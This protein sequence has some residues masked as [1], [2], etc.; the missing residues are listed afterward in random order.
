MA[1][2]N[3]LTGDFMQS[4]NSEQKVDSVD[5]TKYMCSYYIV[6]HNVLTLDIIMSLLQPDACWLA[7]FRNVLALA[8]LNIA[9]IQIT[10]L[11]SNELS[12]C[13]NMGLLIRNVRAPQ[14]VASTIVL[15]VF[16]T[17]VRL[18]NK[19]ASSYTIMEAVSI[20]MY[21]SM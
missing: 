19:F 1:P 20:I 5:V 7:T 21:T 10:I 2:S 16:S 3:I 6:V 9:S 18:I 4:N 15:S 14:I 11:I 12:E 17:A 8:F 13:T